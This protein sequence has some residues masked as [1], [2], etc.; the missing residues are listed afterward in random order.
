MKQGSWVENLVANRLRSSGPSLWLI[1]NISLL[2]IQS[3]LSLWWLDRKSAVRSSFPVRC[4]ALSWILLMRHHCNSSFS[5]CTWSGDFIPFIRS[6]CASN[7]VLSD[8]T[9]TEI[10]YVLL[11]KHYTP[12]VATI[13]LRGLMW[14]ALSSLDQHLPVICPLEKAPQPS[15]KASV[16]I[17]RLG[18]RWRVG[19][20]FH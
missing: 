6:M 12:N 4:S 2:N 13:S 8:L 7:V 18:D 11:H 14:R 16:S 1:K 9:S 3:D 19:L 15:F 17:T 20:S 5:R 10:T